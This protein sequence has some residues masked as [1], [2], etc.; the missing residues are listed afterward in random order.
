MFTP[1]LIFRIIGWF[2][3]IISIIGNCSEILNIGKI[4]EQ[5]PVSAKLTLI[6]TFVNILLI[7][8]IYTA[9]QI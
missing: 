1:Y 5:K 6:A 4:P 2:L 8:F 9:M 7:W 3:I